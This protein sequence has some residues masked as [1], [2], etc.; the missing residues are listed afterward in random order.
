[1]VE[2]GLGSSGWQ[3]KTQKQEPQKVN[4]ENQV[5]SRFPCGNEV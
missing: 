5:M 3:Q 2:V 4:K 1:M